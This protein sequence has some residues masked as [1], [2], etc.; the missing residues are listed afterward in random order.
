M[1]YIVEISFMNGDGVADE[2]Y[3]RF[4]SSAPIP[5]ANVGDDIIARNTGAGP[6]EPGAQQLKVM[7][8]LFTYTPDS[9]SEELTVHVQLFCE[10]VVPPTH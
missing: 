5:I 1:Q 2:E 9:D 7:Q 10:K 3:S 6:G 8:R 4:V